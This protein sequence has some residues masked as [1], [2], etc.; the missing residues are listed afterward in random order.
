[1]PESVSTLLNEYGALVLFLNVFLVQ[2]GLP[3]PAVP[4]LVLAGALA[5]AG[6]L[7]TLSVVV[8]AVVA[9]TIADFGWYLTGRRLGPAALLALARFSLSP[10][11]FVR[12]AENK[13]E[14]WGPGLLL[15]AKFIPGSAMVTPS[16]AG[17]ARMPW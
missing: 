16:L 5:A 8:A 17:M 6:K 12:Q 14:R 7:D 11:R 13:F 3:I 1:M 9:S 15:F 4:G 2:L 10:N